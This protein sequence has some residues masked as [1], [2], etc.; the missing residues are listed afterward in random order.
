[1]TE[2]ASLRCKRQ[3][4]QEE[5]NPSCRWLLGIETGSSWSMGNFHLSAVHVVSFRAAAACCR[6]SSARWLLE[7]RE[8]INAVSTRWKHSVRKDLTVFD[9]ISLTD[10]Y[11]DTYGSWLHN[12]MQLHGQL[13]ASLCARPL[14]VDQVK[15]LQPLK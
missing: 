15:K 13:C 9:S 3:D 7:G 1:M 5:A 12:L 14:A 2:G 11:K 4:R 8:E 6:N 10:D